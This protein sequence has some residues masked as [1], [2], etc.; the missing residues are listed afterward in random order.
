MCD[1]SQEWKEA[2]W[3][4]FVMDANPAR[5]PELQYSD[6]RPFVAQLSRDGHHQERLP[7]AKRSNCGR[8]KTG[9]NKKPRS[10]SHRSGG[11]NDRCIPA[12]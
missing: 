7:V 10:T 12:A 9:S 5:R 4:K 3:D 11:G 8:L 1:L 6:R 2:L